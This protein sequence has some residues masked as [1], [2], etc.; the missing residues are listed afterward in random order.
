[1]TLWGG[2]GMSAMLK[3]FVVVPL[4][5]KLSNGPA[6]VDSSPGAN[7]IIVEWMTCVPH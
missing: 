1:M 7:A 5:Q 6:I 4:D 2:Q 3:T